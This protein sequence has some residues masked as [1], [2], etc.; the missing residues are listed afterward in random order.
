MNKKDNWDKT[1][2]VFIQVK[3]RLKRSLGQ[4]ETHPY[5]SLSTEWVGSK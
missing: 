4:S 2:S 1:E 5:P 3:V